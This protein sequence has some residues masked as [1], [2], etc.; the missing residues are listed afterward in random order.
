[1]ATTGRTTEDHPGAGRG[2]TIGVVPEVTIGVVL[3][4]TIGVALEVT[5]E[6]DQGVT[7]GM[8]LGDTEE[9]ALVVLTGVVREGVMI[10]EAPE[11][12]IGLMAATIGVVPAATIEEV[13]GVTTERVRVATIG[14]VPEVTI[15]D[16]GAMIED[17]ADGSAARLDRTTG[18]ALA[19]IGPI[20]VSP[21]ISSF[22][23]P[24]QQL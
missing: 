2:A 24:V 13:R 3:E 8:V 15:G 5:I 19:R 11:A 23:I 1:M 20:R 6:V 18:M 21:L 17:R 22:R 10:G 7:I 4:V 14:A 12:T 9:V 16:Q